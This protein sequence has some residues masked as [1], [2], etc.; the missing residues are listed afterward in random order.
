MTSWM[1]SRLRSLYHA[2]FALLTW[3]RDTVAEGLQS[4]NETASL[5]YNRVK[6]KTECLWKWLKHI[7]EKVAE[8]EVEEQQQ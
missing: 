5:L 2:L 6:E 1:R 8:E 7:L 4:L 3:T